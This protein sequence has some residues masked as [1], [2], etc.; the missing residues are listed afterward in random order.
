MQLMDRYEYQD[1]YQDAPT[2]VLFS[3]PWCRPC[4]ALK[5]LLAKIEQEY[6]ST[7]AFIEIDASAEPVLMVQNYVEELPTI[8]FLLQGEEQ[9]RLVGSVGQD[10]LD[11]M[12]VAW[13][14]LVEIG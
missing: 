7:F 9:G 12:F 13:Q 11:A 8:L 10:T 6:A 3:G 14:S 4:K 2:I 1:V 5:P